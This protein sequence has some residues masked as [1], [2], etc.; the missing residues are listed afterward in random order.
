METITKASK[1]NTVFQLQDCFP[2]SGLL[3]K[4]SIYTFGNSADN[5]LRG[6]FYQRATD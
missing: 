5:L 1:F 6:T 3:P 4:F 2:T